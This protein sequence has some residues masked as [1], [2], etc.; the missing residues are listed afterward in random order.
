LQ[1]N[2]KCKLNKVGIRP[3]VELQYI[4]IA[5]YCSKNQ[6]RSFLIQFRIVIR[7]N[8][9]S[10]SLLLYGTEDKQEHLRRNILEFALNNEGKLNRVKLLRIIIIIIIMMCD[11]F[12]NCFVVF[13]WAQKD[14]KYTC[15]ANTDKYHGKQFHFFLTF[16][17]FFIFYISFF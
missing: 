9:R 13:F 17:N 4:I 1:G 16:I 15:L 3:E 5:W 14:G 11:S 6:L 2:Y 10:I 8:F 12:T 7:S